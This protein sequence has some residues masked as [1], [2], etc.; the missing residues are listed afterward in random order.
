MKKTIG[1]LAEKQV[2]SSIVSRLMKMQSKQLKST[3]MK[4]RL[5]VSILRTSTI[6]LMTN[7]V[8]LLQS[9]YESNL[10]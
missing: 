8:Q 3:K 6:S 9:D 4:I 7:I 5:T 1:Q 2:T 10:Y